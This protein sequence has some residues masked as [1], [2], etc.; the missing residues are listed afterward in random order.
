MARVDLEL[1]DVPLVS[2]IVNGALSYVAGLLLSVALFALFGLKPLVGAIGSGLPRPGRMF[3]WLFYNAHRVPIVADGVSMSYV[4]L[5]SL[6]IAYYATP[7]V[8]LG[9]SG[10]YVA[11]KVDAVDSP[12]AGF[13]AGASTTLGYLPLVALGA[14]YFEYDASQIVV[15]IPLLRAI[16]LAGLAYP[17]VVGGLGGALATR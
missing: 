4:D 13:V 10:Y 9:A 11:G 17:I 6:S 1:R 7:I 14:V 12:V 2:G 3:G 15:E 16:L 5:A 8:L